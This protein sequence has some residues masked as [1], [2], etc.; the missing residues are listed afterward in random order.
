MIYK[1]LTGMVQ[2]L[3]IV[4][5]TKISLFKID[6]EDI[7]EDIPLEKR[8]KMFTKEC[9]YCNIDVYFY[10]NFNACLQLKNKI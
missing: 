6:D 4:I 3:V 9:K 7:E 8:K 10:A 2:I 5:M 1:F